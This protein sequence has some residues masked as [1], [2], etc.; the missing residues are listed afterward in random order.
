MWEIID[1]FFRIFI[2]IC[3]MAFN[4]YFVIE[5]LLFGFGL[6][7][8][9]LALITFFQSKK[10]ENIGTKHIYIYLFIIDSLFLFAMIIDRGAFY[11]GSDM[12]TYS[13]ITCKLYPYCNRILAT[14]SPMLLV[15]ISV[16]RYISLQDMAR[17][18]KLL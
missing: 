14:I 7:S 17:K 15:Y 4:I 2:L 8:N 10:L 1:M 5:V 13:F 16:E 18:Y 6:I 12:I 11:N 9:L 3:K